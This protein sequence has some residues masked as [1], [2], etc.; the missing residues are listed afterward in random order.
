[1]RQLKDT[2]SRD[3]EFQ[4]GQR[5]ARWAPG[6]GQGGGATSA[7]PAAVGHRCLSPA[8]LDPGFSGSRRSGPKHWTVPPVPTGD[9]GCGCGSG[10]CGCHLG[11]LRGRY[12][13]GTQWT[14]LWGRQE[15]VGRPGS[16]EQGGPRGGGQRGGNP[17]QARG[18]PASTVR[19]FK[20]RNACRLAWNHTLS[21]SVSVSVRSKRP[22]QSAQ[23]CS[24][25]SSRQRV[26]GADRKWERKTPN[27]LACPVGAGLHT[28]P[29]PT[30]ASTPRL[31]RAVTQHVP[32][33]PRSPHTG[34]SQQAPRGAAAWPTSGPSGCPRAPALPSRPPRPRGV[35][36]RPDAPDARDAV[37]PAL[38]GRR[39]RVTCA[40]APGDPSSPNRRAA[41]QGTAIGTFLPSA[42]KSEVHVRV[43][44]RGT[45][46]LLFRVIRRDTRPF[47]AHPG[48]SC[49]SGGVRPV[50]L[51]APSGKGPCHGPAL[52][53]TCPLRGQPRCT[54]GCVSRGGV[55][56]SISSYDKSLALGFPRVYPCALPP[57]TERSLSSQTPLGEPP[58]S[59]L[60]H[61]IRT[62]LPSPTLRTPLFPREH[63][64]GCSKPVEASD[65]DVTEFHTFSL[66]RSGTALGK[67]APAGFCHWLSPLPA[68]RPPRGDWEP[69]PADVRTSGL[70]SSL[71]VHS[72]CR[73]R[74]G[75]VVVGRKS[76]PLA[77]RQRPP[78]AP[79]GHPHFLPCGTPTCRASSRALMALRRVPLARHLRRL[80]VRPRTL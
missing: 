63:P 20:P 65:L 42:W 67:Y 66:Q 32:A 4:E 18:E 39:A 38:P 76:L 74:S 33:M 11:P 13:D 26:L 17:A 14:R 59:G 60:P 34:S 51:T 12:P 2:G 46:S 80:W 64:R 50:S 1:M 49:L 19:I 48:R 70:C 24:A 8:R 56:T 43:L 7:P 22:T 36:A 41:P 68:A 75:P 71:G 52:G 37:A 29:P 31:P 15:K 78:S 30:Q 69:G 61:G 16:C 6:L 79:R 54:A 45:F 10:L 3:A 5:D 28:A 47:C 58:Q 21:G 62:V 35:R 72:A 9:A 25:G 53:P 55:G 57:Q 40:H 23:V 77:V 44:T 27:S 73:P